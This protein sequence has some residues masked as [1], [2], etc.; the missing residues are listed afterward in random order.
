MLRGRASSGTTS[1]NPPATDNAVLA[2]LIDALQKSSLSEAQ[3]PP[4]K[5]F[6]DVR[7]GASL[8]ER[9]VAWHDPCD[10][11]ALD[12]LLRV[13]CG[14]PSGQSYLLLDSSMTG[15]AVSSSLP[16]GE[17]YELVTACGMPHDRPCHRSHAAIRP[18]GLA[19]A[20]SRQPV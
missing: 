10:S 14:V 6:I 12:A 20:R 4:L 2:A 13:A 9:R 1:N 3:R 19:A 15:V 17:V 8:K 7:I 16:S 18:R 5:K 11:A